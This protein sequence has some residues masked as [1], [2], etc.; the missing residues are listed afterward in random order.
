MRSKLFLLFF[1]LLLS[2]GRLFAV[3]A[4]PSLTLFSQLRIEHEDMAI[5]EDDWA[6]LRPGSPEARRGAGRDLALQ[7]PAR[8]RELTRRHNGG[9]RHAGRAVARHAHQGRELRYPCGCRGGARCRKDR[10]A[11]Q[12]LQL[13]G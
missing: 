11:W 8:R 3:E 9:R 6:W 12:P 5:A 7:R 1:C 4:H 13:G 10:P 2:G